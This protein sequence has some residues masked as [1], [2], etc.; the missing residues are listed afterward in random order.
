MA[1]STDLRQKALAYIEGGGSQVE[2]G[3]IFGVTTRTLLN[4]INR[5]KAGRLAAATTRKRKP[6]KIDGDKLKHYIEKHPDSYLREIAAVFSVSVNAICKAY[7]R[8]KITLKKR[9]PS[10]GNG[11]R[12]KERCFKKS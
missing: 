12:K 11:M 4:W 2:A 6:Y 9:R 5:K 7:K 10:T 8:L 1:Y 3:R